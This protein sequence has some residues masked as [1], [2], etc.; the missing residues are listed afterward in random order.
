MQLNLD[1]Q[2]IDQNYIP[3]E[4]LKDENSHQV[5]RIKINHEDFT[6]AKFNKKIDYVSDKVFTD[7]KLFVGLAFGSI[8]TITGIWA[9][10]NV[11]NIF[12]I[13][14]LPGG[15]HDSIDNINAELGM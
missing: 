7:V 6:P 8:I 14:L 2:F 5:K 13:D 10:W 9:G 1:V 4:G 3:L 12:K 15:H 11:K